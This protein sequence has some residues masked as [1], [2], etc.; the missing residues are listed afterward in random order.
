VQV[1]RLM[2]APCM[3]ACISVL[4]C[5]PYNVDVRNQQALESETSLSLSLSHSLAARP[6]AG[7]H[8]STNSRTKSAPSLPL[9]PHLPRSLRTS[10]SSILRTR[11]LSRS[12]IGILSD[13]GTLVPE[14]KVHTR[15]MHTFVNFDFA[16]GKE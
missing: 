2:H 13:G 8:A 12:V 1:H 5:P 10:R 11:L 14:K 7:K 15:D 9:C 4:E 6:L 3:H 16:L